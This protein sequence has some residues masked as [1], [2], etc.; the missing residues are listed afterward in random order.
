[1]AA[2]CSIVPI[3]R[4]V[5]LPRALSIDLRSSADSLM[6]PLGSPVELTAL[7][8]QSVIVGFQREHG[9]AVLGGR[10]VRQHPD[11]QL[12]L[13]CGDELRRERLLCGD[14]RDLGGATEEDRNRVAEP[15]AEPGFDQL[16][17]RRLALCA[18]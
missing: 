6:P 17:Q 5:P 15:L 10:L 13:R 4:I 11:L 16:R 1:L 7:D 9:L 2:I 8:R 18:G 3:V 12:A 14:R